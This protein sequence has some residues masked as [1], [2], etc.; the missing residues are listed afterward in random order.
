[1]T[2]VILRRKRGYYWRL[3][4]RNNR[5]VA[6]GAE[7]FASRRNAQRAFTSMRI[8][9]AATARYGTLTVRVGKRVRR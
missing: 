4:A 2:L 9:A 6:I 5:T 8:A 7:P 3:V 1:M